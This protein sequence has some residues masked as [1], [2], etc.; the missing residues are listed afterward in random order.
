MEGADGC[1]KAA[2]G[3][4]KFRM[5]DKGAGESEGESRFSWIVRGGFFCLFRCRWKSR[6]V[7][8]ERID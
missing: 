1:C 7:R 3:Y 5:G 4:E 8:R 2:V 6:I